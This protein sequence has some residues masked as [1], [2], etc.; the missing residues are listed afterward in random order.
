MNVFDFDKTIYDGDS[1]F[2]FYKFILKRHAR[3]RWGFPKVLGTG[4]LYSLRVLKRDTFKAV[5]YRSFLPHID[6]PFEVGLFWG[7]HEKNIK[8]WYRD[9]AQPSD[10]ISSASPEFLVEP[11]G[12]ILKVRVHASKVDIKTGNLLE[13]NN[14]GEEKVRRF[15]AEFGN[16]EIKQFYS[17][18]LAD[19]PL[20]KIAAEAFMV[21]GNQRNPWPKH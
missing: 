17:D 18:S 20:A 7:T 8:Q 19:T 9:M 15:R 12:K 2:A 4:L 1:T 21:H 16:T 10:L 6:V 14:R 3:A 11:I 13:P 5:L